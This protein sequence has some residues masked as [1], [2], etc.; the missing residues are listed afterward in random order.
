MDPAPAQDPNLAI[1][2]VFAY[3]IG[4]AELVGILVIIYWTK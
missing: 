4:V 1:G 3:A 2:L